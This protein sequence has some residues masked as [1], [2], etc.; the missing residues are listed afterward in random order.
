MFSR[1][2][3]GGVVSVSLFV[4]I[5]SYCGSGLRAITLSR[6]FFLDLT[7]VPRTVNTTRS[8]SQ[9]R[10]TLL[11][12]WIAFRHIYSLYSCVVDQ[13]RR[14]WYANPTNAIKAALFWPCRLVERPF[15]CV[16]RLWTVAQS[17]SQK[18]RGKCS[19]RANACFLPLV[20]LLHLVPCRRKSRRLVSSPPSLLLTKSAS[21]SSNGCVSKATGGGG[22]GTTSRS[23]QRSE[24]SNRK[25]EKC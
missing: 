12:V 25:K 7:S 19:S 1:R 11:R 20:A 13:M 16:P 22:R 14:V 17:D 4:E 8:S 6:C 18:P 21:A 5:S 9:I 10:A 23:S 15:F 24:K 3:A 2:Y